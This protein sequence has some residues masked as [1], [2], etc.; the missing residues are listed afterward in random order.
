MTSKI[1]SEERRQVTFDDIT[2]SYTL[3]RKNVKNL[4][5]RIR[6]DASVA[7]SAPLAISSE[8]ADVFIIRKKNYILKALGEIKNCSDEFSQRQY[9]SG[10]GFRLEGKNLRLKVISAEKNCIDTDGVF[11]TLHVKNRYSTS[12]KEKMVRKFYTETTDAVMND[13]L[14]KLYEI[15]RK[16]NIPK[17][18]LK[19][20]TMKT[21]WGS[22]SISENAITLNS[23]LIEAPRNCI[24]YVVMHELCHMIHPNHS[25]RFYSFL[26]MQ[27]PDWKER[28]QTL[29]EFFF[30]I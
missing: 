13:I 12:E 6:P 23:R 19:F 3:N 25:R 10:E 17:P 30:Q 26:T 2:I 15:F 24:E 27:M 4:N 29:D 1:I 22:C 14:S 21:R 9:I 8:D 18:T 16:Y 5:L 20:R 28:K 7:V 11:L